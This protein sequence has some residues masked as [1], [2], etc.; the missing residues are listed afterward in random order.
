MLNVVLFTIPILFILFTSLPNHFSSELTTKDYETLIWTTL[1]EFPGVLLAIFLVDPI[2]RRNTLRILFGIFT[3]SIFLMLGCSVS[4]TYLMVMLFI[5]R[6]T[7]AGVFQVVYLYTPEV[8][9]TNLRAVAYGKEIWILDVSYKI[10]C[11]H[12]TDISKSNLYHLSGSASAVARVGAM[13]TPYIAQVLVDHSLFSA[14]GV[15]AAMGMILPNS[16]SISFKL[17]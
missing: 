13:I 17:I 10:S 5:A 9:P 2:G 7:M 16:I 11:Y 14:I 6:G 1:A 3:L 4:K 12:H 8:Y 15:Y